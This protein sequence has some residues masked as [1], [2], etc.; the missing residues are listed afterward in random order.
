M[1]CKC[2][3]QFCWVCG[4]ETKTHNHYCNQFQEGEDETAGKG[5]REKELDKY[6]HYYKRYLSHDRAQKFADKQLK[7]ILDGTDAR[8]V[9]Y[10]K[11]I[12]GTSW[13]EIESF[14]HEMEF[15]KEAN[16]QLVNCRRTLKFTYVFAYYMK[17][18]GLIT[19]AWA[20][21]KVDGGGKR[22]KGKC[23]EVEWQWGDRSDRSLSTNSIGSGIMSEISDRSVIQKEIGLNQKEHFEDH[24]RTR[25]TS[26][27][28]FSSLDGKKG[29]SIGMKRQWSNGSDRS[30]GIMRGVSDSSVIE[31]EIGL[32][33][34]EQF[35]DHQRL[36]EMFTEEL[37]E[38][39]EKPAGDIVRIEVIN[40]TKVVAKY[41]SNI[42]SYTEEQF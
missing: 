27:G 37:S 25:Q 3:Y 33:Q 29:K 13:H 39:V 12:G 5:D 31:K 19:E 21:L 26:V 36:L 14:W 24:L 34:K 9:D 6:L 8:I 42:L 40:K 20:D 41:L 22:K 18:R 23:K 16:K 4:K 1:T 2:G 32:R 28:S 10:M 17:D 38:L 30:S 7:E 35:E 11:K 15:L